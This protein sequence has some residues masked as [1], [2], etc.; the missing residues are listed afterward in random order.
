MHP[1]GVHNSCSSAGCRWRA[2]SLSFS[3]IIGTVST[4]SAKLKSLKSFVGLVVLEREYREIA[5]NK[6]FG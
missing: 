6:Q 5:V 4:N 3:G 1:D 2:R